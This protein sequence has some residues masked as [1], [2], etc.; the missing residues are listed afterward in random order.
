MIKQI[1]PIT[2]EVVIFN[3]LTEISIRFGYA[4][5]TIKDAIEKKQT[6]GGFLWE[7]YEND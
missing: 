3:T 4:N 1:N 2:K 5:T 6:F 7:Y